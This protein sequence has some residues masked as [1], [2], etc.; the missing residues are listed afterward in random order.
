MAISIGT[1]QT[2]IFTG[3]TQAF[4]DAAAADLTGSESF[5]LVGVGWNYENAPTVPPEVSAVVIDP[6]GAD[7][8]L[9][10][11]TSTKSTQGDSGAVSWYGKA[12]PTNNSAS[13]TIRLTLDSN[14]ERS[15]HSM[16]VVVIPMT[17][18][19]QT[20]P[21]DN[22]AIDGNTTADGSVTVTTESGDVAFVCLFNE[23]AVE[24]APNVCDVQ[25]PSVVDAELLGADDGFAVGHEVSDAGT[26][27]VT[28]DHWAGS[29]AAAGININVAAA[30]G[31]IE[32][33]RRR[34]EGY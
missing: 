22:P 6:G 23:N 17:G 29:W 7:E 24:N 4:V 20:T 10:F 1:V 27:T 12:S 32:V 8:S 13:E 33:L 31:G 19:D 5:V 14:L 2:G 15:S 11:I 3:N 18:V 25:A 28:F 21:T 34:M 16:M 30:A 26:E 9:S